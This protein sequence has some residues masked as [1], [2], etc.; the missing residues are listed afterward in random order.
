MK[1][2]RLLLITSLLALPLA[3][4][5][6]T[7]NSQQ[8]LDKSLTHMQAGEADAARDVLRGIIDNDPKNFEA[9]VRLGG[10]ELST[11]HYSSAI[12][13]LKMAAGLDQESPRPFIG[14]SLAYIH[15]GKNSLAMA[16]TQEAIRRDPSKKEALQPLLDRFAEKEAAIGANPLMGH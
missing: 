1:L 10:L 14:L 9:H 16:A 4:I 8:A 15:A 12:E 3:T 6:D 11:G 7:T 13:H 5:A 2:A